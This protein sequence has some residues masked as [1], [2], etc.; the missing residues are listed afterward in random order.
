M[1][2]LP[3]ACFGAFHVHPLWDAAAADSCLVVVVWMGRVLPSLLPLYPPG[4]GFLV[5][6]RQACGPAQ[7]VLHPLL[8]ARPGGE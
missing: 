6:L 5:H 4:F 3:A 8:Q 7:D 1:Q 2:L